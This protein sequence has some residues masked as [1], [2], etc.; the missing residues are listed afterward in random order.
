MDKAKN[1]GLALIALSFI[2][3]AWALFCVFGGLVLGA[4]GFVDEQ[5]ML[6]MF[7]LSG[8]YGLLVL[9]NIPVAALHFFAGMRLR[10][11]TGL[12][13]AIAALAACLPQMIMALYCFPFEGLVLFYGI[14]VLA[15]AGV[16]KELEA[17]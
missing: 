13:L 15:D 6:P 4:M 10:Q 5:M 14:F 17:G 11:G 3:A 12:V 8:T 1:L 9:F 2:E 7:V 16:R